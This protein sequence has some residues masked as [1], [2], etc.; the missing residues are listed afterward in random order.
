MVMTTVRDETPTAPRQSTGRTAASLERAQRTHE[1]FALA[2]SSDAER[3]RR[4]LLGAVIEL[5]LDVA[6]GQAGR[7][8]YRGVA[9]DDL[10]QVAAM[11]LTKATWRFDVTRGHDFLS[12]A[13]P[14]IR[15][16]LRKHFRDHGWMVRPP[17]RIQYLQAHITTAEADLTQLLGRPPQPVEIAENL[18]AEARLLV[19]PLLEQLP[20]REQDIVKMRF[21]EC[22]TQSEIGAR[23]GIGQMQVSRL[24]NRILARLRENLEEA[25]R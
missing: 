24:L 25:P 19:R 5:H 20:R 12:Y 21:I 18:G 17:R 14:T 8:R 10:R 13:V 4:D 2:A 11:G 22:L 9:L 23:L 16:E 7:Y 15:G 3:E 6:H 1:L